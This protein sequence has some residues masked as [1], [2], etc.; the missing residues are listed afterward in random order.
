VKDEQKLN[1]IWKDAKNDHEFD[2]RPLFDNIERI[3]ILNYDLGTDSWSE[4]K[5]SDGTTRQVLGT[6]ENCRGK[7]IVIPFVQCYSLL[8]LHFWRDMRC[9]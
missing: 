5:F 7:G 8:C 9:Q 3:C 4:D 6:T 2:C 1:F